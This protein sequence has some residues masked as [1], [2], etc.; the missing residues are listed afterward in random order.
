MA[1]EQQSKSSEGSSKRRRRRRPSRKRR[2]PSQ[3]KS[4][5]TQSAQ[6]ASKPSSSQG[7]SQ[8]NRR[9]RRKSRSRK[10]TGSQRRNARQKDMLD[11]RLSES[12]FVYTHVVY[13]S[14]LDTYGF[15]SDPFIT[16]SRGLHDFRIDL[17]SIFPDGMQGEDNMDTR[18]Y[19]SALHS[20]INAHVADEA[21]PAAD[22]QVTVPHD[23]ADTQDASLDSDTAS[24]DWL[25]DVQ[26]AV[27]DQLDEHAD[28]NTDENGKSSMNLSDNNNDAE[29][30]PSG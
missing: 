12:V 4:K 27:D 7:A 5:E 16:S 21:S 13:S 1:E 29:T 26:K 10:S 28:V 11:A 22:A 24:A 23:D 17:S 18:I 6:P 2:R 19:D 30:N 14:A 3:S 25:G 8:K 9:R 20:P 15:R